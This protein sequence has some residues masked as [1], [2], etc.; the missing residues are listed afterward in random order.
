MRFAFIARHRG[1]WP[2]AW[3]CEALDVSRSG[4]HAW[5][6]RSPS[7]RARQDKV[8]VTKIDRSFK[9]SDRTYGARRLWHDV[10]AEGLSCG[11]HRVERLMRESGLRARP[12]RR[13][14]PKDTGE[15]AGG[16]GQ[17]A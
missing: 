8:L 13:G 15:R 7:A 11:L 3:L 9:S 2:V 10:L 5:L 1:I 4:F 17:P 14:L 12:R 6:N 16:V